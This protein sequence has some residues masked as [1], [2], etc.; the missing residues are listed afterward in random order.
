M[1]SLDR[2]LALWDSMLLKTDF[3]LVSFFLGNFISGIAFM[4]QKHALSNSHNPSSVNRL[5]LLFQTHFPARLPW[6]MLYSL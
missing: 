6:P 3:S 5:Y 4:L 2:L 1:N